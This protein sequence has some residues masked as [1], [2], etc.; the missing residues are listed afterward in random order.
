MEKEL[1]VAKEIALKAGEIMRRYFYADQEKVIKDDGT[2]LTIADTTINRMVIEELAK[3]F[4]E[5]GVIGE[6]ES[7]TEYG[8]GR[9]W[10]C[11]PIDG[12]KAYTWGVPTAMFSLA[13]VVDGVPQVGVAYDPFLDL[14]YCA[15]KGQ[16]AYC[17]DKPIKVSTKQL[18]EG[19]ISITGNLR[20]LWKN[21]TNLMELAK[22]SKSVALLSGAVYRGCLI[23]RGKFVGYVMKY[24]NAHD[25]A[26]I[27][28]IIEEA[29]GKITGL[30]G[31]SLDYSKP[32]HGA[33]MS[34]DI[35]HDEIV[36]IMKL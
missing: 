18:H 31:E 13:L 7:T 28:V 3:E 30:D 14:M 26:A 4:P 6:E 27:H 29:G 21:P 15:V 12:T 24:L 19:T 35:V 20:E 1:R 10:I 5:D 33:I 34:N 16:G 8:M 32:F 11:D 2:P 36:E 22:R 23:A 9:K 25:V 17:N